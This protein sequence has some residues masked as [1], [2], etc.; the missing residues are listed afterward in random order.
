MIVAD[1]QCMNQ[2]QLS[3]PDTRWKAGRTDGMYYWRDKDGRRLFI[4][5]IGKRWSLTVSEQPATYANGAAFTTM[6]TAGAL[7][8]VADSYDWTTGAAVNPEGNTNA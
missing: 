8:R 6:K 2:L 5:K 7:K 1:I 3:T 4:Q